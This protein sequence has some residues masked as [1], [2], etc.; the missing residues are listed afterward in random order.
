MTCALD[1]KNNGTMHGSIHGCNTVIVTIYN[2]HDDDDSL[3]TGMDV[4]P[5]IQ[6]QR[7]MEAM[8]SGRPGISL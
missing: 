3:L 2:Y 8:A 7:R 4:Q 1:R 6:D 5:W